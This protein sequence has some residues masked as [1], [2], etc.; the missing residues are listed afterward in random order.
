MLLNPGNQGALAT[1][2]KSTSAGAVDQEVA[3]RP[4]FDQRGE[5]SC[6]QDGTVHI[7]F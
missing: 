2:A 7:F 1:A 6:R 3:Y 5:L 4:T